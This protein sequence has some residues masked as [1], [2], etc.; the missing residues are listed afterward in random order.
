MTKIA[1]NRCHGGFGLSEMA[2][3][4]YA[5]MKGLQVYPE[6]QMGGMYQTYWTCAPDARPAALLQGDD[7]HTATSEQK[8]ASNKAYEENTI[9]DRDLDRDDETLIAVIEAL[10]SKL[11]S[12]R[13]GA[14]EIVE[15]PDDVEWTIEEYDGLE[16]VAEQ[17]RTWA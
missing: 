9:S 5:E 14:V 15:I 13:F 4:R 16:W 17:H 8:A 10:G 2:I 6:P 3:K 11:A 7:W 12:G 1:I